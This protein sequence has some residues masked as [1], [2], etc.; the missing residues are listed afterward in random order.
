MKRAFILSSFFIIIFLK[1]S[2]AQPIAFQLTDSIPVYVGT[3]TLNNPWAGGLNF[4]LFSQI[5]LNGDGILDLFVYER[6]QTTT[7]TSGRILTFINDGTPGLKAWHFAP[8]YISK[9]PPINKWALLYDYNCDGKIDLF[10]LSDT[11]AAI[12]VWRNDYDPINGLHFTL[13][14]ETL[15]ETAS[16]ASQ[17]VYASAVSL[18]AFGDVDGDGDMDIIG[19][20]PVAD[21]RVQ[22]HKNYSVEN[23]HGCDSLEFNFEDTKW[24]NFQLWIGGT[25]SVA[26]FSCRNASGPRENYSEDF[27]SSDLENYNQSQAAVKDDTISS[28]YMIDIDGDGDQDLLFGDVGATNTLLVINGGTPAVAEMTTQD[29]TF[30]STNIPVNISEFAVHAYFDADND[31]IKDLIVAPTQKENL[32]GYWFY[33]NTGTTAVPSFHLQLG[34][35]F[36][37]EQ[38]IDVGEGAC[39]VLVD[40]DGDG[41]K[42]LVIGDFG[43]FQS[44][45]GV[46]KNSLHLYKNVGTATSPAFQLVDNDFGNVSSLGLTGPVY[47]AFGD[48]DGDGD[49]DLIVGD[50]FG[51]LYYFM[52]TAGA[53]NTPVFQAPSSNYMHIDVG[54]ASTPQLVD[55]DRDGLLDLVVGEKKANINYFRNIGTATAPLFDSIPTDSTL[56]GV[57]VP[58][59]GGYD[60]YSV[61]F[62]FSDNGQYKL[63]VSSEEGYVLLY[64]HID[65]NLGGNFNFVD[66]AYYGNAGAQVKFNLTVSGGDLN[67]DGKTDMLLGLYSGGVNV[68]MQYQPNSVQEIYSAKPSFELFPNPSNDICT[69]R[70]SGL[71]TERNSRL[72]VVNS[73]GQ[74]V[75]SKN[76]LSDQM[77][78]DTH[79][80]SSGVYMFQLFSEE[81]VITQKL[82][83]QH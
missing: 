14:T 35:Q 45:S 63:L 62:F 9:F 71:G 22:Y 66:T 67:G 58:G 70:F 16:P 2:C 38:M 43:I 51:K 40:Y 61:P 78:V 55:L 79:Q 56:G 12:C 54:D 68:L 30:P 8:E 42:D 34:T 73:L 33:K 36:L 72:T 29:I 48:L 28:V 11:Q 13:V 53:G 20:G 21:G 64:D 59:P 1:T 41:L 18:P 69:I 81:N 57:V 46:Y 47:P 6:L 82:V 60:G 24:G 5:D 32:H 77:S 80:L 15:M 76:I 44:T 52:N 39:P 50:G 10:T 49:I 17:P 23:G 25:N 75:I 31:G 7:Y 19:Y 26:C 37:A 74:N 27:E 4:P 3:D 83:I 65:G